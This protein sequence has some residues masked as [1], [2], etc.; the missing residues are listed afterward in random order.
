MLERATK[1]EAF[2]GDQK[3]SVAGYRQQSPK[4]TRFHS[5]LLALA[6]KHVVSLKF[7]VVWHWHL[8]L[9]KTT[10]LKN[11]YG[12]SLRHCSSGAEWLQKPHGVLR[13]RHEKCTI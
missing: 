4:N 11:D 3:G 5:N 13:A 9:P 8:R 1:G 6:Q 12:I 7:V 2:F 10:W